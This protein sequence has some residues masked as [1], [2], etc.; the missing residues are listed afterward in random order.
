MIAIEHQHPLTDTALA[1]WDEG[2]ASHLGPNSVPAV[3]PPAPN[4]HAGVA[5]VD[6]A[7]AA[8]WACRFDPALR[9]A[10]GQ[11]SYVRPAFR[12]K[13]VYRAMQA[14]YDRDIAAAGYLEIWSEVVEGPEAAGMK[15]AIEA[16]GGVLAQTVYRRPLTPV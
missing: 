15:A 5:M 13:G 2:H 9:R 1:L 7:P 3:P 11:L 4:L 10:R 6:G 8:I 16:R 14:V 12:R